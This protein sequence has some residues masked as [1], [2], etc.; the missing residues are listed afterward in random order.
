MVLVISCSSDSGAGSTPC[1]P[2]TCL[3]GGVS[4]P[5]CG[6]SCPQGY[7]GA[8]CSTQITPRKI[9]ITKI[10]VKKFPNLKSNGNYWDSAVLPGY[11]RPD[12]FPA[13]YTSNGT[14]VLFAGTIKN[15][16]WSYGNDSFDFIPNSPIEIT[17]LNDMYTIALWDDDTVINIINQEI[18]GY[19]DFKIY[20]ATGGFPTTIVVSNTSSL[21]GFELTVSYTW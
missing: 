19:I 21:V 11:E 13:L 3:N 12:I 14:I 4:T 15:D 6:C 7:S 5:D 16:S 20:D 9:T 18:M 10:R 2:L 8:N 1:A 17:N